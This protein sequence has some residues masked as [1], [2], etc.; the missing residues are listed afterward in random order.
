MLQIPCC[1]ESKA[2]FWAS[3][4]TVFSR[5]GVVKKP[6]LQ[7]IASPIPPDQSST[8]LPFQHFRICHKRPSEC[9]ILSEVLQLLRLFP[10]FLPS[11]RRD[12]CGGSRLALPCPNASKG[13][14][15]SLLVLRLRD[16]SSGHAVQ[17]MALGIFKPVSAPPSTSDCQKCK[18]ITLST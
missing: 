8:S 17:S 16:A 1:P 10:R 14:R 5:R 9:L 2:R 18:S 15:T 3:C 6:K 13:Q 11:A 4:T 7:T 12:P